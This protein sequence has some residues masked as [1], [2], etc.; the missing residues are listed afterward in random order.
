MVTYQEAEERWKGKLGDE[1]TDRN[2]FWKSPNR[3]KFWYSLQE[4]YDFIRPLEIGCNTC[5]NL[6]A[7]CR[8]AMIP[9]FYGI[10]I[11]DHAL[12]LAHEIHPYFEI[13]HGSIIDI[14]FK[15]NFFDLVFTCGVL[16]HIPPDGLDKALEEM[17]RVSN[18][19]ILIME[20]YAEEERERPFRG[21]MGITWERPYDKIVMKK[22]PNLKLLER[23]FLT[24]EDGFNNIFY[25]MF[26]KDILQK[27]LEEALRDIEEGNLI[28]QEEIEREIEK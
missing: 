1:Y 9:R 7:M 6:Y 28:S 5:N 25:W 14:P 8:I 20:Y 13:I 18:K 16:I 24:I 21:E 2:D 23:G 26:E 27:D 15:D 12:R 11:N 19:Y 22:Y 3:V 10:E 4:K 17:Y